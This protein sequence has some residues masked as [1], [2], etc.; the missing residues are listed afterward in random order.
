[1]ETSSASAVRQPSR[2]NLLRGVLIIAVLG[3]LVLLAVA[4]RDR[5]QLALGIGYP[6][7][8]AEPM[9]VIAHRGDLDRYP[10][11]TFEAIEAA[12]DGSAD[13]IE[14]DVQRSAD[15]IWYV[16]HDDTMDRT[17][18]LSGP[19]H[20]LTST[21][22]DT[23]TIDGG[24]GYDTSHVGL[25]V[26]RL[27]DVLDMLRDYAGSLIVDLQHAAAG[28]AGEVAGLLDGR[29]ATMLVRDVED[30]EAIRAADP[31]ITVVARQWVAPDLVDGFLMD[32]TTEATIGRVRGSDLPVW[33][34][35]GESNFSDDE[36]GLI[37]RA[38][39]ADVYAFLSK[40]PEDAVET[41]E[42]LR[43]AARY[44][45]GSAEA[46]TGVVLGVGLGVGYADLPSNSR[47]MGSAK[48][49]M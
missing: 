34:Y 38:W 49:S 44:A 5:V 3:A 12:A 25:G 21:E 13:G 28:D 33:T 27:S 17:T 35:V 7:R 15:G 18:D 8:S 24:L 32:A 22:I 2:P 4:S 23:A 46:G 47:P 1:M 29:P 45:A 30:I 37:R 41:V 39:A 36:T 40:H 14:F 42:G 31:G 9:L 6:E 43:D 20:E 48:Y 16:L 10:E 19:V 26:P 11:D